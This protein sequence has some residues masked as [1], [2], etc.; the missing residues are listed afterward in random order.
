MPNQPINDNKISQIPYLSG[1]TAESINGRE[2]KRIAINAIRDTSPTPAAEISEEYLVFPPT[3]GFPLLAVIT[4]KVRGLLLATLHLPMPQARKPIWR[5]LAMSV[6][7]RPS[8]RKA[9]LG[10]PA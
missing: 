1:A 4:S 6:M 3:E 8:K 7:L 5:S 10:M 2:M 9:G